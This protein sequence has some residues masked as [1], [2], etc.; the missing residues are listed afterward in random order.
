MSFSAPTRRLWMQVAAQ[1]GRWSFYRRLTTSDLILT[2]STFVWRSHDMG[3]VE[4]SSA[5]MPATHEFGS[6]R[7]VP[8]HFFLWECSITSPT[9]RLTKYWAWHEPVCVPAAV[10]S[11]MSLVSAR[12]MIGWGGYSCGLI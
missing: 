6:W 4:N 7:R 8:T 11:S 10:S 9:N 12:K 1:V 2:P 3:A 5:E